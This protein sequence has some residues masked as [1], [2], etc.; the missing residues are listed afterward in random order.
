MSNIDRAFNSDLFSVI[1]ADWSILGSFDTHNP[2]VKKMRTESLDGRNYLVVPMVMLTE[3][4]HAG[5]SGAIYYSQ[6]E[7][8]TAPSQWNWKPI[9]IDHPYNGKSATDLEVYKK[10]AVGMVMNAFYEDGKLKAEAWLDVEKIKEKCPTV[11]DH[12]EKGLPMEV[13]T[14]LSN[15]IVLQPGTW[16]GENYYGLVTE[17]KADHLAI[18]PRE[19]G[20]CSLADGAGLLINKDHSSPTHN[21]FY[22]SGGNTYANQYP[23]EKPQTEQIQPIESTPPTPAPPVITPAQ[24]YSPPKAQNLDM[25]L[26]TAL[27]SATASAVVAAMKQEQPQP[28]QP[29]QPQPQPQ[30]VQPVQ[31]TPVQAEPADAVNTT[32]NEDPASKPSLIAALTKVFRDYT[33]NII[34]PDEI[35]NALDTVI[36]FEQDIIR[37]NQSVQAGKELTP[38][39]RNTVKKLQQK[40]RELLARLPRYANPEDEAGKKTNP[41]KTIKEGLQLVG[42]FLHEPSSLE[43]SALLSVL[44]KHADNLADF[45]QGMMDFIDK[46]EEDMPG[47]L[48]KFYE[49]FRGYMT[50]DWTRPIIPNPDGTSHRGI[51]SAD[52]LRYI[53]ATSP[54]SYAGYFNTARGE[55]KKYQYANGTPDLIR[56]PET[57]LPEI[58]ESDLQDARSLARTIDEGANAVKRAKDLEYTKHD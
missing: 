47:Y 10:Q 20:A 43:S 12:I 38:E 4:V 40:I 2:A 9:V 34:Q 27:A 52:D 57:I 44:F 56:T 29:A 53:R 21:M 23:A 28:T 37:I 33:Q 26:V 18:L 39:Q 58:T 25:D 24:V 8:S 54:R 31:P 48:D 41:Q 6:Q 1:T 36:G 55:W 32:A 15:A 30:P 35:R 14:G 19:Q 5:S 49:K 17:I 7:L 51:K 46:A 16:K 22:L 42:S 13:S 11:I 50:N 45:E 3:G